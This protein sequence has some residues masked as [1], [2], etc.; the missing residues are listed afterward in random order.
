MLFCLVFCL[1]GGTHGGGGDESHDPVIPDD[2]FFH[3]EPTR[4]AHPRP[5]NPF[6]DSGALATSALVGRA[7]YPSDKRLFHDNGSRFSHLINELQKWAGGR[8]IGFNNSV[9]L[10]QKQKRLKTT[11]I[12]FY[13]KGE[14]TSRV[15]TTQHACNARDLLLAITTR[16]CRSIV[17]LLWWCCGA[18]CRHG[19]VS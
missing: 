15:A 6:L 17:L 14:P 7:H 4:A 19:R 1:A 18:W 12:S 2:G 3:P 8:R 5:F 11:A 13:A 16:C 10:A 9:F